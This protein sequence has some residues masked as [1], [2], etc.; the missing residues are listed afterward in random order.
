MRKVQILPYYFGT[1]DVRNR[2]FGR[3]VRFVALLK[4][5]SNRTGYFELTM[6]ARF[7][8]KN[9]YFMLLPKPYSV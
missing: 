9:V 8:I 6:M 1:A 3:L 7:T 4:K 5:K 2:S